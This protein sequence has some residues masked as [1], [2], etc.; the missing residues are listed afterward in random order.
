MEQRY[1]LE[2]GEVFSGRSDKRFCSDS[3]RNSYHNSASRQSK[4]YS[5]RINSL[6][7]RNHAILAECRRSGKTRL[8]RSEMA[9]KMFSEKY[10]TACSRRFLGR[11]VYFCYDIP[12]R[13]EG[14]RGVRILSE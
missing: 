11:P 12:Y 5:Y 10:C 4:A 7:N 2:C 9:E 1:C 6:L 8:E 13:I 14:R 3:C